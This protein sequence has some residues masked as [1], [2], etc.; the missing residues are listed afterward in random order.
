MNVTTLQQVD[1]S[2]A[3]GWNQ[4]AIRYKVAAPRIDQLRAGKRCQLPLDL[5][6]ETVCRQLL[7]LHIRALVGGHEQDGGDALRQR[8]AADR[9]RRCG[10]RE[11]RAPDQM[12]APM[13]LFE[14]N[15]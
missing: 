4:T 7:L 5:L 13:I 1:G 6:P 9:A 2:R 3:L 8:V 15:R 11:S 10:H 12:A 14:D